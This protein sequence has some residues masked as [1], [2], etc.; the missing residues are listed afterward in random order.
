VIR[1]FKNQGTEDV[2][3]GVDSKAARKVCAQTAM[4]AAQ[5]RLV[6][7]E[8]AKT[9][10]DLKSP[11]YSLEKLEK[12]RKGQHAIRINDRYRVCFFW[13]DQGAEQVEVTD[14]H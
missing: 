11:G 8:A 6:A 2:F 13:I 9:L 3:N 5:K 4:R 7:L 12:D 1:S 14:Y 10:K